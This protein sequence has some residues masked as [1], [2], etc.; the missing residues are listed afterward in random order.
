MAAGNQQ[1]STF[2]S[3]ERDLAAYL[4]KSKINELENQIEDNSFDLEELKERLAY[5]QKQEK[6]TLEEMYS[7]VRSAARISPAV[8]ISG[9]YQTGTPD[10]SAAT[11]RKATGEPL[12]AKS[13]AGCQSIR[14]TA[15]YGVSSDAALNRFYVYR[16]RA[17]P[18]AGP[19]RPDPGRN[20]GLHRRI[21]QLEKATG[22]LRKKARDEAVR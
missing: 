4:Q 19:T 16:G 9:A 6:E 2:E 5:L 13:G 3:G 11:F 7:S 18:S 15:E 21:A 10:P 1:G 17:A 22:N 20:I 8:L 12:P 14:W